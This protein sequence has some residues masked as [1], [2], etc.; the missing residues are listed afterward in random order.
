MLAE[1]FGEGRVLGAFYWYYTHFAS[2]I[3]RSTSSGD[4]Q[5]MIVLL[6]RSIKQV[7]T[8]ELV[9]FRLAA[10]EC[11]AACL[12]LSHETRRWNLHGAWVRVFLYDNP[13]EGNTG[14]CIEKTTICGQCWSA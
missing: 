5:E 3:S 6:V 10:G 1:E 4:V 14:N 8:H 7:R 13:E 2:F 11:E 9:D 12:T